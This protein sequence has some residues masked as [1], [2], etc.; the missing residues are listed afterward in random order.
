MQHF[1]KTELLTMLG[2]NTSSFLEVVNKVKGGYMREL[3]QKLEVAI[4]GKADS[5]Q[6]R[7]LAHSIKGAAK[8]MRFEYLAQYALGLEK[9]DPFSHGKASAELAKIKTE[10]AEAEKLLFKAAKEL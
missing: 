7:T 2:G 10:Y 4:Q 9:L 3:I 8:A 1:N 6:I 5:K